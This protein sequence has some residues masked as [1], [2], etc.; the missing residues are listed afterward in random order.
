MRT[1][2]V[3]V[4]AAFVVTAVVVVA[5]LVVVRLEVVDVFT[6]VLEEAAPPHVPGTH[7]EYPICGINKVVHWVSRPWRNLHMLDNWQQYPATQVVSPVQGEPI[8]FGQLVFSHGFKNVWKVTNLRIGP[9]VQ[10]QRTQ[11]PK[12]PRRRREK[13]SSF[14]N[15]FEKN[16]KKDRSSIA[17]KRTTSKKERHVRYLYIP[18]SGSKFILTPSL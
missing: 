5:A 13:Q 7:C 12:S 1:C 9:K 2:V 16:D 14:R 10:R 11:G 4:V 17:G 18:P 3:V 8:R 15:A 6:V